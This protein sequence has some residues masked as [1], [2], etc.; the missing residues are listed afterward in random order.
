MST[1]PLFSQEIINIGSNP[2]DGNGDAL[3]VA[4]DKVNN[5]FANLYQTFVNSTVSYT[6][7]NISGQVIFETPVSTFTQGQFYVKTIDGGTPDTQDIQLYAQLSNDGTEV[8]FT[9][10]GSTF[11]GNAVAQYDMTVANGNVQILANPL[12][13]DDM[14]HLINSQVMWI[15]PN[16]PGMALTPNGYDANAVLS[17]QSSVTLTSEQVK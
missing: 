2:N 9:G 1:T 12:V 15:G 8:K 5:N 16:G 4:F 17:T 11:F 7:G 10:Y 13:S 6:F 3:R 14:T